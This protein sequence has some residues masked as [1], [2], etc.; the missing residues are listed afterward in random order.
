MIN[1]IININLI[2]V[3][4][5]Q[6]LIKMKRFYNH[7]LLKDDVGHSKPTTRELPP[8]HFVYGKP[9][10]RDLEGASKGNT[11]LI[12]FNNFSRYKLEVSLAK[13]SQRYR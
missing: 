7:L 12:M 4:N 6:L 2:N 1:A 13:Q 3:I 10:I 8:S 11:F 5:S 9:E